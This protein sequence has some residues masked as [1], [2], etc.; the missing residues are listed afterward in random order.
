MQTVYKTQ[1]LGKE[2][3]GVVEIPA[4]HHGERTVVSVHKAINMIGAANL[5][6][7]ALEDGEID[8]MVAPFE[9]IIAGAEGK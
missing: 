4:S 6:N 5:R 8:E 7:Y 1:R 3:W 2:H 9:A